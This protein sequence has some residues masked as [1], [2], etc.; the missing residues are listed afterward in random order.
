[1]RRR[2]LAVI[3][4]VTA[5]VAAGT[6]GAALTPASQESAAD[7]A[8]D[9]TITVTGDGTASTTPDKA[10]VDVAVVAEGEDPA[11]IREQLATGAAD[12]RNEL[13]QAGVDDDQI[14]TQ[15]YNIR[16]NPRHP[17]ERDD[18]EPTYRGVHGFRIELNQTD[19]V[20]TVVDA[21]ANAGAE[22]NSV[23]F[24]L[25]EETRDDLR[26]EALQNAMDDAERQAETLA[27]AG[28]LNVTG[29]ASIDA[30]E[31]NYRPVR[32]DA[33]VAEASDG[34]GTSIETGDV[35]VSVGVQVKYNA[36]G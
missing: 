27:S 28:N 24:T 25:T 13:D 33:A 9:R 20:G 23:Q 4:V 26:D 29:V 34:G 19:Q 14:T 22:V 18:D 5:L 30:S 32:Y 2:N 12:L 6:A 10:V 35:S 16:Q 11:A 3:A 36:T 21:A 31:R 1:M 15:E 17:R 7:H 8:Q